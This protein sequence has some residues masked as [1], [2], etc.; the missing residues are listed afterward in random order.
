LGKKT[1][2]NNIESKGFSHS[3][4]VALGFFVNIIAYGLIFI[5]LPDDSPFGDTSAIS[6]IEPK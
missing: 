3:A 1:S 2:D 4:V 6:L 5:N